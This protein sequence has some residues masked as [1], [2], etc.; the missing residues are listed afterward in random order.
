L[1]YVG[2]WAYTFADKSNLA[3]VVF[4]S[5][6]PTA[7]IAVPGHA[8]FTQRYYQSLVYTKPINDN[9][10]YVGQTDF[11]TQRD[12]TFLNGKR[13]NWYGVNQYLYY[14]IN[15]KWTWG[16]NFEW[17]R[18]EEGYRVASFLPGPGPNHMAPSGIT[19]NMN[20]VPA[21][22]L[23]GG[24]AGNFF[25]TTVGPRWYPTGKPNFFVRPNFR[26]DWYSGGFDTNVNPGML[27]PYS[28]GAKNQQALF[29]TDVCI[30]F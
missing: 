23:P 17:W 3:H 26:Y 18:D 9:W 20:G 27:K 6:E 25:Q 10:T 28:D 29:V 22:A 4:L 1:G 7:N 16:G 13:A 12:A 19:G 30:I 8:V 24:Y 5:Q 2:S 14:K 11:G 21:N 15:D